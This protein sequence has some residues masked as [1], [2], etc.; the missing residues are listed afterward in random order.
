MLQAI[1]GEFKRGTCHATSSRITPVPS[2]PI[3]CRR[4]NPRRVRVRYRRQPLRAERSRGTRPRTSRSGR[5]STRASAHVP[6][7][8]RR[9]RSRREPAP[10]AVPPA[11]VRRGPASDHR[12]RRSRYRRCRPSRFQPAELDGLVAFIRAGFD[13]GRHGGQGRR[14][15]TRAGRSSTAR[16]RAPPAIACNGRGPRVAPDLSDIGALRTPAQLQRSLLDPGRR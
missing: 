9:R 7:P 13:V 6:R 16:A 2:R 12:D 3:G 1:T 8:E 11:D 5:G 4:R 14:R 10:R 15:R